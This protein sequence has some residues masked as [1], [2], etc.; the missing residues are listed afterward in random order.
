MRPLKPFR[1]C[2]IWSKDQPRARLTIAQAHDP[3]K[4]ERFG[5]KIMRSTFE[6]GA[7]SDAKPVPTFADRAPTQGTRGMR[8][9][10]LCR[11]FTRET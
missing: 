5:A 1:G 2:G 9:L 7:R 11:F 6:L 8:A 3:P 10:F 4:C